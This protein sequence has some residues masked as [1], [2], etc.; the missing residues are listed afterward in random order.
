MSFAAVVTSA[1]GEWIVHELDDL[2]DDVA[3]VAKR[4]RV[5]RNEGPAFAMVC[6]ED[7]YFAIVRPAPGEIRVLLSDATMATDDDFAAD[8]MDEIGAEIPELT[9][10]ELDRIDPW[11]EGDMDILS[12]LG[13]GGQVM[14][15]ICDDS[16]LWASEQLMRIAAEIGFETELADALG[17]DVD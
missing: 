9:D 16:E 2:P 11:A 8:A 7:Q 1:G 4:V 3:S 15:I 5:M 12:D 6:V 10:E 17:L 14:S 13:C